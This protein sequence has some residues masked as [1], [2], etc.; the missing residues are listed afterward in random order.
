MKKR[1]IH[2]AGS[3]DEFKNLVAC[4]TQKPVSS[5]ALIAFGDAKVTR[6]AVATTAAAG[7]AG[8]AP[9]PASGLGLR[10]ASLADVPLPR[11]VHEFSRDWRRHCPRWVLRGGEWRYRHRRSGTCFWV[12]WC[13]NVSLHA[14]AGP[15]PAEGLTVP[16]PPPPPPPHSHAH[17]CTLSCALACLRLR[18]RVLRCWAPPPPPPQPCCSCWQ[19][20]TAPRVRGPAGRPAFGAAVQGRAGHWGAGRGGGLLPAV[21]GG[22]GA[23]RG[24]GPRGHPG[25]GRAGAGRVHLRR[26]V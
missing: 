13:W 15:A 26:A 22:G 16:S 18:S 23:R 8:P 24:A 12:A 6:N 21:P 9:P 3:Y 2:T 1:A 11:T 25:G 4:A 10:A 17:P 19:R 7:V 5:G 20:P 14:R